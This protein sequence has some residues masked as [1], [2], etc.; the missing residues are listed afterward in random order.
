MWDGLTK[1]IMAANGG[2]PVTTDDLVRLSTMELGQPTQ[3]LRD[4]MN[5]F[6]GK[7]RQTPGRLIE[8]DPYNPFQG[9]T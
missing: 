5:M 1:L 6:V 8:Q 4:L 7:P 9:G 3:G 2:K